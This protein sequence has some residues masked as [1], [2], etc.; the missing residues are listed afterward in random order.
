MGSMRNNISLLFKSLTIGLLISVCSVLLAGEFHTIEKAAE[1]GNARAQFTIGLKYKLG[2]GVREDYA[3][4]ARWYRLAAEQGDAKAQHSLGVLYDWGDGVPRDAAEAMR[5]YR[6]A[7]GQGSI[8]AYYSLG[9]MYAWSEDIPVDNVQ[10]Y[11]WFS[12]ATALGL[13]ISNENKE[14][15][16]ERMTPSQF[17]E[18]QK[19]SREYWEAYRAGQEKKWGL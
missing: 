1:Q 5:W 7:A 16:A 10:A 18:A 6:L 19:L 13:G 17:A 4:A 11:A 3:E 2:V 9:L 15:I 14:I 12:V 8:A